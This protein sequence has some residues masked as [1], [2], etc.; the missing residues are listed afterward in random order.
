M[1]WDYFIIY[2][3]SVHTT[4]CV[5]REVKRVIVRS[6]SAKSAWT[7]ITCMEKEFNGLNLLDIRR[8]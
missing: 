5:E 8:V 1:I 2:E 4:D 6:W 3:K 7:K